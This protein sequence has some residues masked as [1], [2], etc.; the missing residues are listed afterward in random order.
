MKL[1]YWFIG[2]IISTILLFVPLILLQSYFG[3]EVLGSS[4]LFEIYIFLNKIPLLFKPQNQTIKILVAFVAYFLI[5][6]VIGFIYNKFK[7]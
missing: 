2:G 7:K 6:S 3:W 5:G 1:P 4:F